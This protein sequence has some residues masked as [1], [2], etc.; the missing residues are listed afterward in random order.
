MNG[1]CISLVSIDDTMAWAWIGAQSLPPGR[2][3]GSGHSIG[4][5]TAGE[6]SHHEL[7]GSLSVVLNGLGLGEGCY[8]LVFGGGSLFGWFC[9]YFCL[10][11]WQWAGGAGS[12]KHR[13]KT[14]P[15]AGS[16]E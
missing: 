11:D 3:G 9:C 14:G 5:G 15:G 4:N 6:H 13:L 12:R 1:L 7:W 10:K 8:F 16:C 2:G